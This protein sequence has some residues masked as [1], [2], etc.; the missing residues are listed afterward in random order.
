MAC[1]FVALS[2][3]ACLCSA[4]HTGSGRGSGNICRYAAV[5]KRFKPR[6]SSR[7]FLADHLVDCTQN[8]LVAQIYGQTSSDVCL[9]T[10]VGNVGFFSG[11]LDNVLNI[12]FL[13]IAYYL[14]KRGSIYSLV[15]FFNS[16]EGD[17]VVRDKDRD[18]DNG[19]NFSDDGRPSSSSTRRGD[20]QRGKCPQCNG[21]GAFRADLRTADEDE[22]NAVICDLCLGSGQIEG[23]ARGRSSDSRLLPRSVGSKSGNR[24]GLSEEE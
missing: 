23:V 4:L 10:G 20:K 22:G 2:V 16:D 24:R 6:S 13:V 9:T 3:L 19:I 8:P 18:Y 15:D 11:F 14:F 1:C 5:S 21:S 7:L 17:G 12:G